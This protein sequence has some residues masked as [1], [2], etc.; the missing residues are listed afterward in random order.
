MQTN[1]SDEIM[2]LSV[3]ERIQLAE[4]IWDSI[5]ANQQSVDL[6]T[7]QKTVLQER[8]D[9]YTADPESGDTWDTVRKRIWQSL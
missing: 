2:Q 9:N 3:P 1:L 8:L 5:V 6:S 7:I 4:D